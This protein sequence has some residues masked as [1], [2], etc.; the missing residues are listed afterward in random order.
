L[1][2]YRYDPLDNALSNVAGC[3]AVAVALFPTS[4]EHPS[5]AGRVVSVVHAVAAA[6]LLLIFA[7]FCFGLFTRTDPVTPRT[8]RKLTR[9]RIYRLCGTAIVIAVVLGVL[10]ETPLVT[11]GFREAVHPLLWCEW[12][13]VAAFGTAWMVKGR[14]LVRD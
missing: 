13:A 8:A 9:D 14:T 5:T 6:T 11:H 7:W 4:D 1:F 10:T 2:C 3:A 12:V